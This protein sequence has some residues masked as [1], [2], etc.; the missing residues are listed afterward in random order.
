MT[1]GTRQPDPDP[2]FAASKLCITLHPSAEFSKQM[3]CSRPYQVLSHSAKQ[4][5]F[6][7][8]L[9]PCLLISL[10]LFSQVWMFAMLLAAH[11]A[12]P[13][14]TVMILLLFYFDWKS[15]F[16]MRAHSH[17]GRGWG[18]YLKSKLFGECECEKIPKGMNLWTQMCLFTK[19]FRTNFSVKRCSRSQTGTASMQDTLL[20][21]LSH[22]MDVD[23][24]TNY[25]F[26]N[27]HTQPFS[28]HRSHSCRKLPPR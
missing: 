17:L 3:K 4:Q 18:A 13:R 26:H 16:G 11:Y 28:S 24:S 22:S 23:C 25:V 12:L 21:F 1:R 8:L 6:N 20:F 27:T 9:F 10:V 2:D 7:T 5:W 15:H 19:E 14:K